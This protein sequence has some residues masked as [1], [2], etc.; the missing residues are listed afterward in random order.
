LKIIPFIE[1]CPE[2]VKYLS[3][4]EESKHNGK[5]YLRVGR[6]ENICHH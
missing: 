6:A 1:K 5:K 3:I 2:N 4:T